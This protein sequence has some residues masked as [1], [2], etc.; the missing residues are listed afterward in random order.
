[1][2]S[3]RLGAD[4]ANGD[5]RLARIPRTC[6]RQKRT[7]Q[8]TKSLIFLFNSTSAELIVALN[9]MTMHLSRSEEQLFLKRLCQGDRAVFWQ[10]WL[11]Y[12]DCLQ[13][14]CLIWMNGNVEDAEDA[15]SQI[16]LKAWEQLFVHADRVTHLKAWLMRFTYNFCMDIHRAKNRQAIAVDNIEE[17]AEATRAIEAPELSPLGSEVEIRMRLAI[18]NLPMRLRSPFLMRFEEEMSYADIAQKLNISRDN[19]YKRIS[20]A[21][22]ILE[23]QMMAYYSDNKDFSFLEISLRSIKEE[24]EVQNTINLDL[25]PHLLFTEVLPDQCSECIYC[26]SS[27]IRKNGR[28]RGKQNYFCKN[29]DRQF[30]ESYSLR[31]YEAEI[32]E[33]CLA[34][35]ADGLAFRAIERETGVSHNTVINWVKQNKG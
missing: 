20:Q 6:F 1:M 13:K 26:Q 22:A 2:T 12:Q 3:S 33:R 21:R 7:E 27:Q 34:L 9:K 15:F 17:L 5:A 14:K 23:P 32:K 30:I 24:S 4:G 8:L 31:G 10:L 19:V 16:T 29:C 18:N 11:P 28:K 25:S 35:Y